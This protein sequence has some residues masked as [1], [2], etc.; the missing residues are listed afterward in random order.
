M[1][2]RTLALVA[3]LAAAG[4]ATAQPAQPRIAQRVDHPRLRAALHEL[5]E[6]RKWL[7][8]AKDNFPPGYKER[9]LGSTEAAI[10]DIRIMLAVKDVNTFVGVDRNDEYYKKYS[11]SPRLRAALDDLRDARDELKGDKDQV[12]PKREDILDHI[13]MAIGDVLTL[14]RYKPKR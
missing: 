7:S 11:D 1:N 5:R 6:A 14:I 4:V 8:E 13:D 12:G 9:A 2:C 3:V 10:E